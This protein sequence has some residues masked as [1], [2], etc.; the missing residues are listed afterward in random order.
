[1]ADER[2]RLARGVKRLHQLEHPLRPAQHVGGESAGNDQRVVLLL[3]DLV[4]GGLDLDWAVAL[5]AGDRF[6]VQSG[7]GHR[8]VLLA[9]SVDRVEQFHVLEQ[10]SGKNQH[11]LIS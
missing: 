7:H 6:I 10:G 3:G 1:V 5:L 11:L 4:D 2:D 8:D 9:E